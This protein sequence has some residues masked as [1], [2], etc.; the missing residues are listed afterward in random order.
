MKRPWIATLALVCSFGC[1]RLSIAYETETH[2]LIT[3]QAYANSVLA[4]TPVGESSVAHEL[5]LDRLS[6]STPF[7]DYWLGL[8]SIYYIDGGNAGV[9]A[10]GNTPVF[11]VGSYD[12]PEEFERC[13]MNELL[14][15]SFRPLFVDTVS[16]F[17][18]LPANDPLLPIQNWIVRGSIREDDLGKAV[19]RVGCILDAP[20]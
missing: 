7:D 16:T 19:R 9:I 11:Q 2:A 3:R 1:V 18:E 13:Q 4:N 6:P 12:S 20:S 15:S 5:G 17:D 10:Q 14:Q 8:Y